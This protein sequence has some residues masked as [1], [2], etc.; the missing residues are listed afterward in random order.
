MAN[1]NPPACFIDMSGRRFGRWLVAQKLGKTKH[2]HV[3]WGCVCDCGIQK[4]VTGQGLR[5]GKSNS[6][7]CLN[8]ELAAERRTTHGES[9]GKNKTPEYLTFRNMI[10]RCENPNS[11]DWQR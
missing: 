11:T 6:C 10:L 3:L 2:N 9:S 4:A 5:S 7:G 1:Y 8:R